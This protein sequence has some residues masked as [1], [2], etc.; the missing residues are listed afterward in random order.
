MKNKYNT[1]QEKFWSSTFGDEYTNRNLTVNR[2]N[3]IGKNLINN[4]I[5][6]K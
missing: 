3:F 4:N 5:K 6:T 1:E 2:L